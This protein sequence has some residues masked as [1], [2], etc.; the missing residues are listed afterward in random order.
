LEYGGDP[1]ILYGHTPVPEAEWV[2]NTLCLDTGCVFGGQLTALR[3]PE[4]EI[5]SVP[6]RKAYVQRFRPFGHP[7]PRPT[8]SD[9][10]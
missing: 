6:A 2:N 5:V 7:P 1:A 9:D 3:W 10:C 4:R 8:A